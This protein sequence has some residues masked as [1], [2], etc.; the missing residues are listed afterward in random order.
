MLSIR[1]SAF[2]LYEK[3]RGSDARF[4][5]YLTGTYN[6]YKLRQGYDPTEVFA[7]TRSL[8]RILEPFSSKG[9]FELLERAGFKRYIHNP[10]NICFEGIYCDKVISLL[11]VCNII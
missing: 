11:S 9:N 6:E 10:E 4:Q 8:E 7:K 2:I 5:D 1:G 3:V